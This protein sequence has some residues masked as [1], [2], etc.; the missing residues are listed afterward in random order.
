MPLS[1]RKEAIRKLCQ[2]DGLS[3]QQVAQ[4]LGLKCTEVYAHLRGMGPTGRAIL[5]KRDED[6]LR[7][8]RVDRVPVAKLCEAYGLTDNGVF[9]ILRRREGE[10]ASLVTDPKWLREEHLEKGR[11]VAEMAVQLRCPESLVSHALRQLQGQ[12]Q[13]RRI[14]LDDAEIRRLYVEDG[15]AADMIGR[16]VGA[17]G[18]TIRHRLREQGVSLKSPKEW[19]RERYLHMPAEVR[20][21]VADAAHAAIRG[22]KKS[23]G[24]MM[25]INQALAGKLKSAGEEQVFEKLTEAGLHPKVGYLL[26]IFLVDLAFPEQRLAVEVHGGN[27]HTSEENL[28]KDTRKANVLAMLGWRTYCVSPQR[29]RAGMETLVRDI[30]TCLQAPATSDGQP[31][32]SGGADA[33]FLETAQGETT[34]GC[35][36]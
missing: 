12:P 3:A 25:R 27:W 11:S 32:R 28:C 20:A 4:K 16:L 33:P 6:I 23:P 8:Y 26:D 17:S 18:G 9:A 36:G 21:S 24:E 14:V 35:L 5:H 30:R 19:M 15:M 2:D 1:E 10:Q 13:T 34:S 31:A 29:D 7:L 22:K